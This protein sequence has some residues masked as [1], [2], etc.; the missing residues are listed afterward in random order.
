MGDIDSIRPGSDGA[1]SLHR[2]IEQFCDSIALIDV[3]LL[4]HKGRDR[5]WTVAAIQSELRSSLSSVELQV[6]KLVFM[7]LILRRDDA[8][9]RVY[10]YFGST[11]E[12]DAVVEEL[13]RQYASHRASIISMI[14]GQRDAGIN[15]FA[16]VFRF[17]K[18]EK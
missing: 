18:D 12:F 3:L 11:P 17:R 5:E 15:A 14:Y 4:L 10:R 7:K 1:S 6:E 16:D 8:D 9:G 2:F 13:S